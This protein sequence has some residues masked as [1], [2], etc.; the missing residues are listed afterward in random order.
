MLDSNTACKALYL[1]EHLARHSANSFPALP[2]LQKLSLQWNGVPSMRAEMMNGQPSNELYSN[3]LPFLTHLTNLT[4]LNIHMRN[5]VHGMTFPLLLVRLPPSIQRLN[6]EGFGSQLDDEQPPRYSV[7]LQDHSFASLAALTHLELTKSS[8]TIPGDSITCL[9]RL[10]SLNLSNSEVYVDGQLEVSQLTNLTC[11]ELTQTLCFW[12]DAWVEALDAFEAWP[13][14]KVLKLLGSNLL[15]GRTVL[16]APGVDELEVMYPHGNHMTVA[17][18]AGK[19]VHAHVHVLHNTVLDEV[20]SAPLYGRPVVSLHIHQ[21]SQS[22]SETGQNFWHLLD[23]C[24]NLQSLHIHNDVILA[25]ATPVGLMLTKSLTQLKELELI[26]ITCKDLDFGELEGLTRL[27]LHRVDHMAP[28]DILVMPHNLRQLDFKGSSMF[29]GL[30]YP[31][32]ASVDPFKSLQDL[33]CLTELK[34][35][36]IRFAYLSIDWQPSFPRFPVSLR[37]LAVKHW[38]LVDTCDWSVL[39]VCQQ[40]ERFT[41]PGGCKHT[42]V[43]DSFLLTARHLH[44]VDEDRWLEQDGVATEVYHG[45]RMLVLE[46]MPDWLEDPNTD[47]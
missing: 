1:S 37:Y 13:R 18:A 7:V 30:S 6:L 5:D 29:G 11:L 46:E 35:S 15:D 38:H 21:H 23:H 24:P 42:P 33:T 40:L 34:L 10:S 16:T 31:P 9:S 3:M 12:E 39:K 28:L 32:D 26:G 4:E 20:L 2:Q 22:G 19:K 43:L 36:P 27:V 47:F 45:T 25:Q 14:L 17:E 44:V 41:L 8:V